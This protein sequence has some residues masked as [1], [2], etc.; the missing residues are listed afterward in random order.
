MRMPDS[1]TTR[2]TTGSDGENIL[3]YWILAWIDT[4]FQAFLCGGTKYLLHTLL[5]GLEQM[6]RHIC[7]A[8]V[9][10]IQAHYTLCHCSSTI[11]LGTTITF[12]VLK[13]RCHFCLQLAKASGTRS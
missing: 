8:N 7:K 9:S 12:A 13:S 3:T 4:I 2:G 6:T 10:M 1:I 11:V 5:E